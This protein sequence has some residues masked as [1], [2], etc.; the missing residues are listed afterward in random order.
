[1][2]ISTLHKTYSLRKTHLGVLL[3]KEEQGTELNHVSLCD[4]MVIF[5][6]TNRIG[7]RCFKRL[8]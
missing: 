5:K 6:P 8:N 1:M 4:A 3:E 2:K 7:H